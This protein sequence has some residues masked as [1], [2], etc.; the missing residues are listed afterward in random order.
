MQGLKPHR[1]T[2]LV[3]F[4]VLGLICCLIFA[5]LAWVMGNSDLKEMA[6]GRMDPS[7]EGMAKAGKI[8][9]MIGVALNVLGILIWVALFA[10][11]LGAAAMGAR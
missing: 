9:G 11:G 8:M 2:M 4:G 5:I 7:G 1:G 10:L 6:E 3:I